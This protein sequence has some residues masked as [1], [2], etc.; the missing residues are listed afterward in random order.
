MNRPPDETPC[1]RSLTYA[2]AIN[3]AYAVLILAATAF[4]FIVTTRRDGLPSPSG[5]YYK[6]LHINVIY[7]LGL[8]A[9]ALIFV[10]WRH[11]L[12]DALDR[13][14]GSRGPEDFFSAGYLR[15][16]VN[17]LAIS[18]IAA[19]TAFFFLAMYGLYHFG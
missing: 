19:G 13:I 11:Q 6:F 16:V 2:V 17:S 12:C 1:P 5:D 3:A 18:A 15:L 14:Y 10:S 4:T 8:L 9:A 7:A